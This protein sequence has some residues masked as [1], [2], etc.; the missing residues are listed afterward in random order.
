MAIDCVPGRGYR[1]DDAEVMG[2]IGIASGVSAVLVLAL[3]IDSSQVRL[4]YDNPRQLWLL[5]PL[6]LYWIARLWIIAR[7]GRTGDPVLFAVTDWP[8][9]CVALLSLLLIYWK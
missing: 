8:S 1:P 5:C 3:Y 6:L 2:S 4:I 7:R 9:V